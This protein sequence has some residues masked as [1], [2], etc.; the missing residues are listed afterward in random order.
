MQSSRPSQE[1]IGACNGERPNTRTVRL[2]WMEGSATVRWLAGD[3]KRSQRNSAMLVAK[4][5]GKS[6]GIERS[7][8]PEGHA[9]QTSTAPPPGIAVGN[10]IRAAASG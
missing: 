1:I 6:A 3:L 9:R 10:H 8:C 2:A 4:L 5:E 7:V